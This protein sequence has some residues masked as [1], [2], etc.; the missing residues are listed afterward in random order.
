MT[1]K[2]GRKNNE[3]GIATLKEAMPVLLLNVF[4][5]FGQQLINW[6]RGYNGCRGDNYFRIENK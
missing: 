4:L 2:G 3:G 6:S 5:F 1:G